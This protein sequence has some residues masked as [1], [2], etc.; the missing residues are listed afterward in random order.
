MPS[1][2]INDF[3]ALL[4]AIRLGH[5]RSAVA[6]IKALPLEVLDPPPGNTVS[7]LSAALSQREGAI[8]SA[9][10]DRGV[11]PRGNPAVPDD[12]PLLSACRAHHLGWV[13]ALLERGA[14]PTCTCMGR[15]GVLH[16]VLGGRSARVHAASP[17]QDHG[18]I[19]AATQE[20]FRILLEA[21]APA[22]GHVG[23]MAHPLML[24]VGAPASLMDLLLDYG[25]NPN[26][27]NGAGNTALMIAA[28]W[29][30]QAHTQDASTLLRLMDAGA[31]PSLRNE[32][33]QG[34]REFYEEGLRAIRG[35]E[36]PS[37]EEFYARFV[38]SV[39]LDGALPHP[40]SPS[41][42]RHRL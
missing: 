36:R 3:A 27:A 2:P 17:L 29:A 9:L 34:V 42:S 38:L 10:L 26:K 21:G 24:V 1:A 25:A 41:A 6:A 12:A 35:Q 18:V 30:A 14:D 16:A 13:R 11:D 32:K 23:A 22:D 15:E 40:S 33:G 37:W 7:L 39:R 19:D 20:L 5:R 4:R 28:R 31:D 8:V